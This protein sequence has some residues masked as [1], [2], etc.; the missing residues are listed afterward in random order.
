MPGQAS[1]KCADELLLSYLT[2]W[3]ALYGRK[4]KQEAI[5]V[6]MRLFVSVPVGVLVIALEDVTTDSERMPT[7]G[8][9]KKAISAARE[10]LAFRTPPEEYQYRKS[11]AK[12]PETGAM[13]TVLID[14]KEQDALLYRAQDCPEGRA[15]LEKL[16]S[17][18]STRDEEKE[19]REKLQAQKVALL[20]DK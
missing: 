2:E 5:N 10:R 13:V 1:K 4:L 20:A 14:P 12:D 17:I 9:L 6:W 18:T 16:R 8:H 3:A 15:F 19:A 11:M 7:P